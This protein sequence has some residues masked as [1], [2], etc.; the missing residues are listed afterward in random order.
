MNAP[1]PNIIKFLFEN[2]KPP[3]TGGT[4]AE[5]KLIG[6]LRR[7]LN[8]LPITPLTYDRETLAGIHERR[9]DARPFDLGELW[10]REAGDHRAFSV[11][12][13]GHS[14]P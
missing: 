10:G 3:E 9:Y 12:T 13:D 14:N 11:Y 2:K 8:R 6:C 4:D 5:I 1:S 7:T